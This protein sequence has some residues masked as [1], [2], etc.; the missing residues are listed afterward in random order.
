MNCSSDD[1]KG[2]NQDCVDCKFMG[3]S[4]KYCHTE[5]DDFYTISGAGTN[6]KVPLDRIKWSEAKAGLL[7]LCD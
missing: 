2:S 1:N 3:T 4:I 5:G 6:T 7:E